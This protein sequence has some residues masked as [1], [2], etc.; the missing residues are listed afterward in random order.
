MTL[1]KKLHDH[2]DNWEP[3]LAMFP[4]SQNNIPKKDQ[5]SKCKALFLLKTCCR[6][7]KRPCLLQVKDYLWETMDMDLFQL[8][9]NQNTQ[10]YSCSFKVIDRRFDPN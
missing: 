2:L 8:D 7:V 5:N 4:I 1:W 3:H 6:K 10:V 9:Q